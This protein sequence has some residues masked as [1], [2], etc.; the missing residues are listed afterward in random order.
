[1]VD[2]GARTGGFRPLPTRPGAMHRHASGHGRP[3]QQHGRLDTVR[4]CQRKQRRNRRP[5]F[6]L[7]EAGEVCL[8]ET[9][10]SG[11]VSET[12]PAIDT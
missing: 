6:S 8:G 2:H 3:R 7:L 5:P 12:E 9:G 1:M 4:S 10:E 11:D